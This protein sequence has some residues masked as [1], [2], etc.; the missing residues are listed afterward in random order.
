MRL[1]FWSLLLGFSGQVHADIYAAIGSHGQLEVASFPKDGRFI[2]FDPRRA[3]TA[4]SAVRPPASRA[5]NQLIARVAGESGVDV[6]LLHAVVHV[7]SGYDARAVSPAG[8]IGLM[9]IMPA[10]GRRFGAVNLYDPGENLRAGAAYLNWLMR[11]FDGDLPLVIA[12]YNAGEQAVSRHGNRIPPY[13]E[14][15]A[16]VRRVIGRYEA[17]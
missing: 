16:Y 5:V 4:A 7:E 11:R 9:Q 1:L 12:A 8:A 2:R 3:P 17:P 6:Q 15:R 13:P 14:T 10:T